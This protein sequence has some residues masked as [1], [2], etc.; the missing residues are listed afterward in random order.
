MVN[1]ILYLASVKCFHLLTKTSSFWTLSFF[2]FLIIKQKK[3]KNVN[4]KKEKK[5]RKKIK[6]NDVVSCRLKNENKKQNIPPQR[7]DTIPKLRYRLLSFE[8]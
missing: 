3:L 4:Y 1:S 5:E 2:D 8:I 7:Y 6:G